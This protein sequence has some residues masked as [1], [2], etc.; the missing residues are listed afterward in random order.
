ML[1]EWF[2]KPAFLFSFFFTVICTLV[3]IA[4]GAYASRVRRAVS[5]P[6]RTISSLAAKFVGHSLAAMERFK[7]NCYEIV[8]WLALSILN[9]IRDTVIII[10]GLL[11][12][13]I[14]M[15]FLF[16]SLFIP[17]PLLPSFAMTPVIVRFVYVYSVL[18]SLRNYDLEH[19]RLENALAI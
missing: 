7:D 17:L 12:F 15:A 11:L 10:V 4:G 9:A 1:P 5:F 8:I 6:G 14:L 3:A 16:R 2:K 19:S 13:N 18:S